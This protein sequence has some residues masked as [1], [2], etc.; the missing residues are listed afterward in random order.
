MNKFEQLFLLLIITVFTSCTTT[1]QYIT[2]DLY[3]P[4]NKEKDELY[5]SGGVSILRPGFEF[6]PALN[7]QSGYSLSNHFSIF[8]TGNFYFMGGS[9]NDVNDKYKSHN[10]NLCLGEYNLGFSFF[11]HSKN[12]SFEV[13]C[14]GGWGKGFFNYYISNKVDITNTYYYHFVMNEQK[15]NFYIQP[16]YSLSIG[17]KVEIGLFSRFLYSRYYDIVCSYSHLR[18]DTSIIKE[19]EYYRNKKTANF[20]FIEPGILCRLKIKNIKLQLSYSYIQKLNS[21]LVTYEKEKLRVSLSL[22]PLTFF[23]KKE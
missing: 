5:I 23:K 18:G 3:T 17:K 22:D 14:A 13:I 6:T 20:Y 9:K 11:N 10:G 7:L 21:E 19:N 1:Y 2:S 8:G 4:L 12:H 16:D 15:A